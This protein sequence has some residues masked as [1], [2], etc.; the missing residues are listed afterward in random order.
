MCKNIIIINIICYKILNT[1]T[2]C[3]SE[4][5]EMFIKKFLNGMLG[6]FAYPVIAGKY[7]AIHNTPPDCRVASAPYNGKVILNLLNMEKVYG[8]TSVKESCDHKTNIFDRRK[9]TPRELNREPLESKKKPAFSLVEMLMALLVASLLLA[10]L[11]PV[12]TKKFSDNVN[13]SGI[14]GGV[15]PQTFC[16]YVNNGNEL[17]VKDTETEGCA[18]PDNTYSM[19][20]IMASGGGGGAGAV[21]SIT[22]NEVPFISNSAGANAV[23]NQTYEEV[24]QTFDKSYKDFKIKMTSGGGGTG[25][26]NYGEAKL[27]RPTKQSDCEPFGVYISAS[28]N[29]GNAICVSKYNPGENRDGSPPSDIS[30]VTNVSVGTKCTGGYCCWYGK[31][32]QRACDANGI[33]VSGMYSNTYSGCDRRVCQQ[34][35]ANTICSNWKPVSGAS[36]R[37]PTKK[38]L[39]SWASGVNQV[40]GYTGFLNRNTGIDHPGLQLCTESANK[41]N[42]AQCLGTVNGC[43]GSSNNTCYPEGLWTSTSKNSNNTHFWNLRLMQGTLNANGTG[44]NYSTGTHDGY[45]D[46]TSAYSFR[47]VTDQT[48]IFN[49]FKGGSSSS[50]NS[51]E[52][53]IPENIISLAAANNNGKIRTL[54]GYGGKGTDKETTNKGTD[55]SPS[56]VGVYEG[57]NLLWALLLPGGNGGY[58]AS[59]T[60]NGVNAAEPSNKC[61]Y[62]DT[63][64]SKYNNP[65]GV[66]IECNKIPAATSFTRGTVSNTGTTC[67]YDSNTNKAVCNNGNSGNGG[68][69]TVSYKKFYPGVG[70]GGGAAGTVAHFKNVQVRPKDL[71]KVT[72]GHGG[73]GGNAGANGENGGNSIVEITREG[74]SISKY[75]ISGGG[76]GFAGKQANIL[77]NTAAVISKPGNKSGLTS[78]TKG[79]LSS[80]DEYYPKDSNETVGTA[81]AFSTDLETSPGGNGGINSKISPLASTDGSLNGMPCGGLNTGS[82]VVNDNTTWNCANTSNIPLSLSRILSESSFNSDI[83]TNLAAGS[84]GGGGGGWKYGATPQ[85]SGGAKGMGGYVFIYFGEW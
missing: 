29:G 33:T 26:G 84:T 28:Q 48:L 50:G 54:S 55:G 85:A 67:T 6:A 24:I 40:S 53:S 73:K 19:N 7:E 76:G 15:I 27:G 62:F 17:L 12:M 65:N 13:I 21:D 81:G 14:G 41:Y 79:K 74:S 5:K 78:A 25:G 52:I 4:R 69:V 23:N 20:V 18:V 31:T 82:V 58:G 60:A 37:L 59:K 2:N 70:G 16:A 8:E 36:G 68:K 66:E 72:T 63:T 32:A 42:T 45:E 46:A 38:E 51:I 71:I 35:A 47:C 80:A 61:T 43:L 10:A 64:N 30:G 77:N 56:W 1:L 57:D 44:Y 22:A 39:D 11:A 83:I 3:S 9:T 75:E 49:P 34:K